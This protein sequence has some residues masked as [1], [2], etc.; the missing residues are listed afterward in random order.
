[1]T[2]A[3]VIHK[4]GSPEVMRWEEWMV[5]EPA[6]GRGSASTHCHW[7]ELCRCLLSRRHLTSMV[8]SA[9][10]SLL[11]LRELVLLRLLLKE[12]PILI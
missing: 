1:M 9:M 11:A 10:L 4:H 5:S 12:S 7:R 8:R 2:K 6:E 3:Q